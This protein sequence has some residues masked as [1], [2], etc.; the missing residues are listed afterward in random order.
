MYSK[1]CI[2]CKGGIPPL[3]KKKIDE[4]LF[5]LQNEWIVNK[6]G[7]LY[8]KYKF[9]DFMGAI[10]FANK[11]AAIAEQEAHHPD[12]IISWGAC[13]IEIWTHKI[14]GLTESD[15]ILAAKIEDKC[16]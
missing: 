11:I 6:L 10:E 2:P 12:L 1:R 5:E 16:K 13:T 4:L 15:F 14:N 7:H 9:P 3:D 8:K